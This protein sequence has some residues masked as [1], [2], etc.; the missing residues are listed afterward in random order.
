MENVQAAQISEAALPLAAPPSPQSYRFAFH[1]EGPAF[2]VLLLKNVLLTIITLGLYRAWAKTERRK[3]IWSNVEVH[4]HRLAFTG[5]GQEVFI[6]YLKVAGVYLAVIAVVALSGLL[7]EGVQQ[8]VQV[9]L[10]LPLAILIPYAIYWSR[11]YLLSRTTWRGIRFGLGGD[12]G[13]FTRKFLVGG[14]LTF[15]TLGLYGPYWHNDL[16]RILINNAHFGGERF[17]YD[18]QGNEVFWISLRGVLLSLLTLGIYAFWMQAELYR[19]YLQHTSFS[20]ARGR[21][22]ITGGT[23]FTLF[24]LNLLGTTLTLGL[25]FPWI[26]VYTARTFLQTVSFE[27]HIDFDSIAQTAALARASGDAL[28][29]AL[30]VGLGL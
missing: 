1:G 3:F 6:A 24:L 14:V 30:D 21:C 22:E 16:R 29:D 8:A 12:A 19:Y 17:R 4:G 27:G 9:L 25:A 10:A 2:F 28:A 13:D 15:V 11:A 23:L 18:G 7:S 5:T 26:S 20:N